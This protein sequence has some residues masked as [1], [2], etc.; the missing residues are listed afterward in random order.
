MSKPLKRVEILKLLKNNDIGTWS[1]IF[2][3]KKVDLQKIALEAGL[4]NE[5]GFLVSGGEEEVKPEVKKT[6]VKQTEVKQPEVKAENKRTR[7]L[8][9]Q[10]KLKLTAFDSEDDS[11]EEKPMYKERNKTK[12]KQTV[13]KYEKE[14]R[15]ILKEYIDEVKNILGVY[16]R[17]RLDEYD[18][19]DIFQSYNELTDDLENLVNDISDECELSTG[20][21]FS[22]RFLDSI[23]R[24]ISLQ[25]SKVENFVR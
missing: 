7:Q 12:T 10:K 2:K 1:E 24:K 18:A 14:I 3:L 11:E 19:Q 22:D 5:S 4:I 6:E 8:G 17:K 16:D 9:R 20:Q 15:E 23:E 13:K 25:K 21:N